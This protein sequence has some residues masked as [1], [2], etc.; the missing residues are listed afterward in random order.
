MLLAIDIGNTTVAIG[1]FN[2]KKLV[3]DWR[4]RSDRE[5]TADE[6]G[7]MLRE[8]LRTSGLDLAAV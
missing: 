5:K 7:I 1:V 8:L 2:G 3:E 6:Y 4:V